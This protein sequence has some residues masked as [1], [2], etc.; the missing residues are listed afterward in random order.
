MNPVTSRVVS[1]LGQ[2]VPDGEGTPLGVIRLDP[3]RSYVGVGLLLQQY[4]NENSAEA[5]EEIRAKIDYTF[6]SLDLLLTPWQERAGL[7]QILA[8]RLT[9]GRKLLF[10]P[11]LVNPLNIDFLTH[12][13]GLGNTACTEWP[14]VAALMRWFHDR[15]GVSYYQ[16]SLGEAATAMSAVAGLF[17]MNHP[18]GMSVTPEAVIEGRCGA[19]YGGWGFYFVRKYLQECPTTRSEEDPFS[20]YQ[21]S[22]E[23]VYTPPGRITNEL[24]VVDLNRIDD[25]SK[26]REIP[27][28][29]GINFKSITLHKDIV[30]GDPSDPEDRRA[31]PGCVLVNVPKLKVHNMSLFTNVIKNLGIGLYPMGFAKTGGC[32]WEYSN[33]HRPIPGMKGGIPHEVWV[34]EMDRDT[35]LPV[36][37]ERGRPRVKKTGG[38]TATMLDIVKAVQNQD[39]F[40]IHI[41]DAI[42]ATNLDHMGSDLSKKEKEGMVFAGLD[43]VALDLLCARYIF[44]NVPLQEALAVEITDGHGGRFPQAVPLPHPEDGH[45]VTQNGYDCPLSRDDLPAEAERR[46]VGQRAYQVLGWDRIDDLPIVSLEG[47]LGRVKE[48]RFEDLITPS[49]YFDVFKFAWDLQ[50]TALAYFSAL[51]QLTGSSWKRMFLEAFDEDGDGTVTYAETGK[52]GIGSLF[53]HQG[54]YSVSCLGSE[55]FGHLSGRVKSQL[56]TLKLADGKRNPRGLNLLEEFQL[57]SACMVALRMSQ[58]EMEGEDLFVPGLRWGKGKWPSLKTAQFFLLGMSLYGQGFPFQPGLPSLYGSMVLYA[59]LTQRQG[60]LLNLSGRPPLPQDIQDYVEKVRNGLESPLD[61]LF[62]VPF[63]Y[64]QL[65]GMPLP[66]VAATDDP[67]KI[68]TVWFDGG[69]EIWGEI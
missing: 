41:V 48:G 26:G 6:E 62:Y 8:E 49:L 22:L 56:V 7:R 28:P 46:G 27:V 45:I 64:E 52:K 40:M 54:G 51:D 32:C 10:K 59:D 39:I 67:A 24:R 21:A 50:Q 35:C 11:N 38:L 61:F 16:M 12:G 14:F 5:W 37:D 29:D 66:N 13:P 30:G 34:A 53:L 36:L 15:M 31:Y 9:E 47:H 33:P 55:P 1:P 43:P 63:G 20:G 57:G 42:E 4:I 17:S 60:T 44:S 68:L 3:D 65:G 23:G 25:P 2:R 58:M 69:R 18:E 19:F